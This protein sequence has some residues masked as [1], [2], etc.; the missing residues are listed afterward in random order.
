MLREMWWPCACGVRAARVGSKVRRAAR[1][2]PTEPVGIPERL[3]RRSLVERLCNHA[4]RPNF[5]QLRK[6][7]RDRLCM[8]TGRRPARAATCA[9]GGCAPISPPSARPSIEVRDNSTSTTSDRRRRWRVG[10]ESDRQALRV[11]HRYATRHAAAYSCRWRRTC[12]RALPGRERHAEAASGRCADRHQG[13]ESSADDWGRT[14]PGPHGRA[15]A[16]TLLGSD[17]GSCAG[18]RRDFTA[19][20]AARRR[21]CPIAARRRHG[22]AR[23]AAKVQRRRSLV[24]AGR[25]F[26]ESRFDRPRAF[27][28]RIRG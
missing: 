18:P 27:G 28:C 16:L 10:L 4:A 8:D 13:F 9:C 7:I 15:Q 12:R 2:R 22:E 5:A 3:R 20:R 14:H 17:A 11:P 19:R 21:S 23:S 1:P 6:C 24:S 25:G 26:S